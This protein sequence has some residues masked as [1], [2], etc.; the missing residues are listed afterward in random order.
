M[1]GPWSSI[2][3]IESRE[4]ARALA[5]TRSVEARDHRRARD[6]RRGFSLVEACLA[7]TVMTIAVGGLSA[8]IVSAF[9]L[10]RSNHETATAQAAARRMMERLRGVPFV[11]AFSTYNAN[12]ADDP[13]G[14]NTAPGAN[15]TVDG[16]AVPA[17]DADGMVGSIEF[18]TTTT[19]GTG[20][21]REDA[22][23]AA[24]GMPRDLNG[25]GAVDSANHAN[26]YRILPVRVRVRWT[27]VNGVRT[28]TVESILCER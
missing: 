12:T 24:L 27:G 23:D 20:Q 5:S 26:D 9:A 28:L 25:D 17:N 22:T 15:F 8:A 16:L 2:G 7:A 14:A 4:R 10:Q 19:G 13:S 11:E 21:L 3:R 18:P 1:I 6:A